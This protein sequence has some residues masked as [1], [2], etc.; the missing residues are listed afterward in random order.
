MLMHSGRGVPF[1]KL[2]PANY[3]PGMKNF[4]FTVIFLCCLHLRAAGAA[5]TE[6]HTRNYFQAQQPAQVSGQVTDDKGTPLPGVSVS[7]K[8]SNVGVQTDANGRY[9]LKLSGKQDVLVFSFIGYTKQEV[10]VNGRA[11]V[12]VQLS[13]EASTLN[14]VVV[15]AYGKQK[16]VSLTGAISTVSSKDLKQSPVANLSNALA[17][18]LPGLIAYQQSGEPGNDD[19]QIWIRGFATFSGS[20][21]PLIMV[22]GVERSFSSIDA[23][24]VESISILKD[25][26]STAV[27]GIRGANGVVLVTTK[28]GTVSAPRV[29]VSVQNGMQSPTRMPKYLD[30]Y[31]ALSLYKEGL[32]NDGLN[33]SLYTDDYL[34]KFRDRSNPTYQYLYPNV[35]WQDELVKDF[36]R[37]SQFNVNVNG[38]T[39]KAKY[40]VSLSYRQQEGLYKHEKDIKDYNIQAVTNLYNFRSNIDLNITKDLSLELNLGAMI[41]D[42]NYPG[43]D[44]DQLWL[45]AKQTPSWW[46][47][48]SNP[49]GTISGLPQKDANPLGLLTQT[50][51]QRFFDNTTQASTGMNYKMN[52][53]TE[54]LS[55]RAR[56]SFDAVNY[57]NVGRTKG[58]DTYLFTIDEDATDLTQG[59]YTKLTTGNNFLDYNV[60]GNG[61]RRTQVELALNYDRTFGSH[62][63][64]GMLMYLQQSFMD[65]VGGGQGNAVAGLPYKTQGYIARVQYDYKSKYFAEFNAGY[66]GSENFMKGKRFGFFPAFS[67]GWVTSEE[68]FFE[69][70]KPVV[71]FMKLRVSA[72]EVGNDRI[73]Q[74]FLYQSRWTLDAPGYQFGKDYNGLGYGGAAEGF[75]GNPDLTW[76]RSMKYNLG[77][78]VNL[79]NDALKLNIDGFYERRRNIL[80]IPGTV[81]GQAGII[82]DNLPRLNVGVV[83]NK[84]FEAVAEYRKNFKNQGF[85]IRGNFSYARNK[86]LNMDEPSFE[87]LEWQKQ[88]GRRLGEYYGLT[89]VGLFKDWNDIHTSPVQDFAGPVQPGDIKYLDISGDG[90]IDAEDQGYLGK[91]TFPEK[92]L[93]LA[94]GYNWK[95]FDASVLFQG[96]FGSNVWLSGPAVWPFSKFAGVLADVKGNYFSA[97]NPDPGAKYPRMTSNDQPNNYINSTFWLKSTDYVRLKN[98][99][100]GYTFSADWIKKARIQSAR[101]YVNAINLVTWDQV[102]IFDPEIPN[103]LAKYPQQRVLNAGFTFN[104]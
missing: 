1:R 93:G 66:N 73:G 35:N 21:A 78:D 88:T 53:I 63:V 38:G 92:I 91:V 86:I 68:S 77:L 57:R 85:F 17:G 16:K 28:R 75:A 29:A 19:S 37:M 48:V 55:A 76:E 89:A 6:V 67:L 11:Q 22:D 59:T 51:Y 62:N 83:E 74:R 31:D 10:N 82:A 103:G 60:N 98:V 8:G 9:T 61:S 3:I 50:G 87:G 70:I 32:A 7:L 45:R 102:K 58:F 101:L 97:D 72:G 79:F 43:T 46:Y 34:N 44:A 27:F 42:R 71:S 39:E 47:P 18:R 25:A 56:L 14:D 81:P 30:A 40:F 90:R 33:T 12:N 49:N 69:N 104:F 41:R 94:L 13:A 26:S 15:V 54:G 100:I 84:G 52:W 23:N 96:A 99:E 24:E 36:A 64:K 95:G 80:S 20:Q 5:L 4:I 2:P 65:A